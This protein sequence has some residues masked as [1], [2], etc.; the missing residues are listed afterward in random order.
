M[1]LQ[2]CM[3]FLVQTSRIFH[4][5]ST[6]INAS[7]FKENEAFKHPAFPWKLSR[8]VSF[9]L[10]IV[11]G[12]VQKVFTVYLYSLSHESL[13][14]KEEM[15]NVFNKNH[16][17]YILVCLCYIT[18]WPLFEPTKMFQICYN[19]HY[20]FPIRMEVIKWYVIHEPTT[21][22]ILGVEGLDRK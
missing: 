11:V 19:E 15:L 22:N 14:A 8:I 6:R 13:R 18:T 1:K 17:I 12:K 5:I 10:F 7:I 21:L 16:V 9:I 3:N 20:V 2:V 4:K